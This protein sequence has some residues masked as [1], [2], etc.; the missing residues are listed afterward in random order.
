V[1]DTEV[2]QITLT[3]YHQCLDDSL[4]RARVDLGKRGY[5]VQVEIGATS[6]H[7]GFDRTQGRL[8]LFGLSLSDVAMG[9]KLAHLVV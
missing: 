5:I 4:E 9:P 3:D 7:D 1:R 2:L 6:R 8:H